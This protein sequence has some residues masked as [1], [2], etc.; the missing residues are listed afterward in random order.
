MPINFV[1]TDGS[2]AN[3]KEAFHLIKNIN[4]KLVFADRVYDT[5]EILSYLNQRN[6]RP[7]IP[8]KC[9]CLHQCICKSFKEKGQ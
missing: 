3:C 5:N 6:I 4:A 7:V 2:Y 9:N 1:V 8:P